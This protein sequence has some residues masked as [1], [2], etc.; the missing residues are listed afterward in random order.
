MIAAH[1]EAE[2]PRIADRREDL[3]AALDALL[4]RSMAIDPEERFGSCRELVQSM[5]RAAREAV[6]VA[7][8]GRPVP[9]PT[10]V[11]GDPGAAP[12]PPDA[13][14]TRRPHDPPAP[15]RAAA[16]PSAARGE[17]APR[18]RR[19][20]GPVLAL[21]ALVF[22]GVAVAVVLTGEDA[23]EM[24]SGGVPPSQDR[25][26]AERAVRGTVEAFAAAEGEREVCVTL[27]SE[28]RSSCEGTYSAAQPTRFDIR[29]VAVADDE[30][31]VV[32]VQREFE[33]PVE[34]DLKREGATWLIDEVD[35]F[36]WKDAEEIQLATTVAR[37]ARGGGGA[38]DL[39]SR[40]V[41]DRCE[42]VR[43]PDGPVR[44]D[45]ERVNASSQTGSVT[46]R[47]SPDEGDDYSLVKELGEW[48]IAG[49]G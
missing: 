48:R 41:R 20:A 43:R 9:A 12:P 36:D 35:G 5:R 8:E 34:I 21:L 31:K 6:A 39:L 15:P 3:P 49:I 33:D 13:A 29:R 40:E 24:S 7:A 30:A 27:V 44:Y 22:V 17:A 16:A 19:P 45:I 4:A 28:D 2:R 26:E 11:A 14:V 1:R 32:A 25:D 23:S 18:R 46:G 38:C 10:V 47:L 37:F 42:D